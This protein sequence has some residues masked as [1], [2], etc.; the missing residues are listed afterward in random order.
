M[1]LVEQEAKSAEESAQLALT[2]IET[3][4]SKRKKKYATE[5]VQIQLQRA[6][7]LRWHKKVLPE[8]DA[9]LQSFLVKIQTLVHRKEAG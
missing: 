4:R 7:E 9:K 8:T 3:T 1:A 6:K 5:L 2:T